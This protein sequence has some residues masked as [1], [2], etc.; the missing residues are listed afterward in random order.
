MGGAVTAIA[1][2]DSAETNG[3]LV[4][5]AEGELVLVNLETENLEQLESVTQLTKPCRADGPIHAILKQPV[6]AVVVLL[7]PHGVIEMYDINTSQTIGEF[8]A[9]A[10]VGFLLRA[11]S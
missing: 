1:Y 5:S 4:G 6:G 10:K 8:K 7:R 11:V 9:G 2:V 3:A